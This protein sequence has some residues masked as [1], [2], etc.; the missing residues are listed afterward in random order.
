MKILISNDDGWSAPG[1][2]ALAEAVQPFADI[3]V[4]APDR[5]R[6]AASSS[7][8]L[9]Q[10]LRA[11]QP[12]PGWYSVDGTPADCV[13]LAFN[14]LL[15]W[16]PDM[17]IS[18]INAG[19]NLGDDVVYS[20]TVAA[21]LE[22]FF[23]GL[24]ALAFSLTDTRNGYDVAAQ[25]AADLIKKTIANAE[26]APKDTPGVVNVNI[27]NV[28]SAADTKITVTRM[29]RRGRSVSNM[30][31]RD[32]RGEKI[33]WIGAVGDPQDKA[34]GTDFHAIAAGEV[35]VTPLSY[36]MTSHSSLVPL[37]QQ[38]SGSAV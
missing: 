27:P 30:E 15:D 24:P 11:T 1:I 7:L 6:S 20:G 16:S 5:N 19:P 2:V 13:I 17:V 29:G 8:T 31:H 23:H 3:K 36:D 18:G 33:Y 32:P 14:G 12:K 25:I 34:D 9:M 4:V 26:D 10:P 38:L 37:A 22:G 35:S 28:A 21:A